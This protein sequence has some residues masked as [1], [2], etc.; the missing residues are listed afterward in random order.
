MKLNI[1]RL[2]YSFGKF[3][4]V[5]GMIFILIFVFSNF[6]A[7]IEL[8]KTTSGEEILDLKDNPDQEEIEGS[9]ETVQLD[10]NHLYIPTLEIKVPIV[11]ESSEHKILEDLQT[12]VVRFPGSADPGKLGNVFI[13]GHSSN[14]WWDNG[15]YKAIFARLSHIKKNQE[16][17]LNYKGGTYIY[18]V[19]EVQ[20]VSPDKTEVIHSMEGRFLL[21]LMTCYPTGT[22]QKRLVVTSEQYYPTQIIYNR[23]EAYPELNKLP[24]VR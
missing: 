10:N 9:V 19:T 5:F 3:I 24:K 18:K 22:I 20:I 11:W 2:L 16:I 15:R 6:P 1:I 17:W 7:V 4:F 8:Q 12:G 23:E 13:V 21:S 14:Y